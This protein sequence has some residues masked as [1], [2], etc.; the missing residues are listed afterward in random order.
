MQ[1][2]RRFRNAGVMVLYTPGERRIMKMIEEF[3]TR[4]NQR[5]DK[6]MSAEDDL[7][8]AV[9]ALTGEVNRAAS[10]VSA[11]LQALTAAHNAGDDARVEASVTKI[12][13]MMVSLKSS[14]DSVAAAIPA[15]AA[16][17]QPDGSG[18]VPVPGGDTATPPVTSVPPPAS[19]GSNVGTDDGSS[20]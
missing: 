5:L 14:N 1:M 8:T 4:I 11:E 20:H 13:A 9:L 2:A 10:N 19:D 6:I 7:D 18:A 12:N 15:A 16:Q 17:G 3:E